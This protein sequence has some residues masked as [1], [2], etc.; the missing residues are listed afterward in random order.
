MKRTGIIM[1]A[2][3]LALSLCA[4]RRK[5]TTKPTPTAPTQATPTQPATTPTILPEMDPTL[6]TN[7]P[8]PNVDPTTD[9]VI[10]DDETIDESLPSTAGEGMESKIRTAK[11]NFIR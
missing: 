5:D 1:I 2:V 11:R 4:C 7:I 10:A 8:D 3:V 9:T 6:D